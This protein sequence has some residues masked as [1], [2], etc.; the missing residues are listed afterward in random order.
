MPRR[1]CTFVQAQLDGRLVG[2]FSGLVPDR[3]GS[4]VAVSDKSALYRLEVADGAGS[5]S[6]AASTRTPSTGATA[7]PSSPRPGTGG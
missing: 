4:V 7:S 1:L 6:W 3:D 5:S 2:G